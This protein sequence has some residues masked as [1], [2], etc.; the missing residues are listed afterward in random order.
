MRASLVSAVFLLA[1]VKGAGAAEPDD[2]A[3]KLERVGTTTRVLVVARLHVGEV[4][5][6]AWGV[7]HDPAAV[8]VAP[9]DSSIEDPCAEC[10]GIRC[11]EDLLTANDG[12]PPDFHSVT[13][14]ENG[15]SQGVVL[16]FM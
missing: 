14:A 5:G 1:A 10:A 7:C 9:C 13:V 8:A 16:S 6:W 2:F 12:R 15:V 11:P 3:I 4:Q